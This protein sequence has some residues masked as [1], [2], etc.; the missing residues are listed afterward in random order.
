[1]LSQ[2]GTALPQAA[3][4]RPR[5]RPRPRPRPFAFGVALPALDFAVALA[6]GPLGRYPGLLQMWQPFLDPLHVGHPKGRSGVLSGGMPS[7]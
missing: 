1:M 7:G 4:C 2:T 6:L 5:A 3:Q